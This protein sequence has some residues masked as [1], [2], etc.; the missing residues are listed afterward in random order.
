MEDVIKT[1]ESFIGGYKQEEN[2]HFISNHKLN[3]EDDKEVE[4]HHLVYNIYCK[5]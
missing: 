2:H 5:N 1:P 3:S 4:L